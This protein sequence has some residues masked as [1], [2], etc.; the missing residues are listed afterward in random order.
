MLWV[1]D[2][3]SQ[4]SGKDPDARKVEGRRRKRQQKMRRLDIIANSMDMSFCKLQTI[5]R[6]WEAWPAAVHWVAKCQTSLNDWTKTTRSKSV[7]PMFSSKSFRVY[8]LTFRFLIPL[9]L[10]LCMVLSLCIGF[11]GSSGSIVSACNVGDPGSILGL[12]RFPGEGNGS[13]LQYS[14]LENYMD[15]GAW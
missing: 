13:P 1:L 14:C 9:N 12:G 11:P 4:L 15:G 8:G 6:D 10:S 3:K 2:S 7:L 5:V